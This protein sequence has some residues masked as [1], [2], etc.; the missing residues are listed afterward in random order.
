MGAQG[1]GSSCECVRDQWR[2]ATQERELMAIV[3]FAVRL[4]CSCDGRDAVGMAHLC[5]CVASQLAMS[6]LWLWSCDLAPYVPTAGGLLPGSPGARRSRAAPPPTTYAARALRVRQPLASGPQRAPFP[7]GAGLRA[8][9][10]GTVCASPPHRRALLATESDPIGRGARRSAKMQLA[11]PRH[12]TRCLLSS[13]CLGGAP[14][15][16]MCRR[17]PHAI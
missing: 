4:A 7:D 2:T 16:Q 13:S 6:A 8:R 15:Q 14:L 1:S 10:A 12:C 11:P 5:V 17:V 3:V 9:C